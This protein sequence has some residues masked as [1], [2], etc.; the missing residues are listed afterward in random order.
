[1]GG[2]KAMHNAFESVELVESAAVPGALVECGV[3][4]GGC[5]AMMGAA[6]L[7][8]KGSAEERVKWLFDSYE[9]LPKP[10]DEDFVEG[11][12]GDLITPLDEG[13][14]VGTYEE[15]ASLMIREGF[16][17]E[18][19]CM[20]K[21]WFQDTIAGVSEEIGLIAVLRLDGDWYESTRLPLDLLYDQVSPGGVVIIDDYGTCFG[22]RKAV[23]E[24]FE[25]K[26]IASV[27][28]PDGRGG[29][30]WQKQ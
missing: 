22:S 18:R 9:G 29:A 16:S 17:Q 13:D 5:S 7:V 4:R 1:M 19:V 26:S 27:L 10:T 21:G 23:N 24:I 8:L 20:I 30:W 15:V 11:Q 12:V 14:C 6:N 3:A 25:E 2:W 28:H